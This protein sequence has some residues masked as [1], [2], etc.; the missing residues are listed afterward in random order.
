MFARLGLNG[1]FSHSPPPPLPPPPPCWSRA[2]DGFDMSPIEYRCSPP[3]PCFLFFLGQNRPGGWRLPPESTSPP[4]IRV[5]GPTAQYRQAFNARCVFPAITSRFAHGITPSSP[6]FFLPICW[7][8]QRCPCSN[9][10]RFFL[11]LPF[12]LE[13]LHTNRRSFPPISFRHYAPAVPLP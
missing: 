5:L 3:L 8:R 1:K 11:L 12:F 6:S 7:P 10:K 4:L 13:F 2:G 9:V